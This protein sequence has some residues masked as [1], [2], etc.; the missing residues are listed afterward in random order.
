MEDVIKTFEHKQFGKIRVLGDAENPRFC[1]SDMCKVL[2]LP[3]VAKVV[4][5]LDKDVLSTHPLETAGGIQQ[6]YFVNEDGFYDVLLDSRKPVAKKF[7][8]WVT[9]EVLPSIRKTGSY[10]IAAPAIPASAAKKALKNPRRRAGQLK[11]SHVYVVL[12]SNNTVKIGNA[13]D[14]DERIKQIES[15]TNLKVLNHHYSPLMTRKNARLMEIYC[16]KIFSPYKTDG[17]FFSVNFEAT[18]N[19]IDIIAKL[20]DTVSNFERAEKLL[21]IAGKFESLSENQVVE[22]AL[23]L[24]ATNIIVDSKID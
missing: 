3:Q 1:L 16:Q 13:S 7:R 14:V 19:A 22:K 20:F 18:C 8:K 10:S 5:R 15:K 2:E 17:E 23:L 6:M 12:L 11:N 9:S 21:A 24:Q 4:Q